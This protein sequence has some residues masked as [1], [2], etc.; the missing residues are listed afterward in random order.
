[1]KKK[2]FVFGSLG[3]LIILALILYFKIPAV[4]ALFKS[5]SQ[6]INHAV[7]SRVFYE[8]GAEGF[9][10]AIVNFLPSA[11]DLVE[12]GHYGP[13]KGK[14]KVYVFSTQ[15]SHNEYLAIPASL[16]IRGAAF[17]KKVYIAS[18]AFSFQGMDTHRESLMHEMSHLF[19]RQ[20]LGFFRARKIP[21]W[22]SE[23]LANIVAG[24]GGEGISEDLAIQAI[25]QGRQMPLIEKGGLLKSLS[26]II[27]EAGL[28]GPMYHRQNKMF[29]GYLKDSN[30]TAF[31]SLLLEVL[32][33]GVF[34]TSFQKN[35]FAS[36]QEMW[37]RFQSRL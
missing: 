15:K 16:P 27:G 31:R 24:S 14:F 17:T 25:K 1:M 23:G 7:D 18:S 10:D 37:D 32:E 20:Y 3:F 11:V 12:Q 34:L 30:P 21:F 2:I 9:A 22:Y 6:F 28:T 36:P 5:K 13:F 26:R 29:V 8:P 33:G 19:L 35:Y 4:R